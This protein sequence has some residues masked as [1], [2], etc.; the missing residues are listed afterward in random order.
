[1]SLIG[2]LLRPRNLAPVPLGVPVR[3]GFSAA[4]TPSDDLAN[5]RAYKSQGTVHS[6]VSLLASSA[7]KPDWRLY[8][9]Q[10]VD[11]RR[12]YTT[13]DEGSDQRTE[14]IRHQALTVLN[15]PAVIKAGGR[16]IVFFTRRRLFEL[17]GI[18]LETTGKSHWVV[19]YDPRASF[20]MGLWPVPP[21]RMTPVP[22]PEVFLAGWLYTSPD[23]RERIPLR[24]Q[25]VIY[26]CYPDPEDVYGGTGPIGSVLANI[27]AARYAVR[28]NRSFFQNSARPDGVIQLDPS[29]EDVDFDR[30]EEQ[31]REAHQ[32]VDR[33]HR[34][35][36]L[37]AGATWQQTGTSPKDMDFANL[38][39]EM[40]DEIREALGMHKVMTGVTDD[41]NRANAQTGEEVFSSWKIVPRLDRW[42]DVLNNQYLPLFGSTG[43]GVEF[44]YSFPMPLNREQ[45]NAEL[46]A[47][48]DAA[49]ALA[50][51]GVWDPDDILEVV[52]LPHMNT[53]STPAPA[54]A[55]AAPGTEG[56]PGGAQP[57]YA[58]AAWAPFTLND[59]RLA[60][61][62]G[63][64]LARLP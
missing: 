59:R 28:W 54:A 6:N 42:K 23:G 19:Q 61:V 1:V 14:V 38:S 12:R 27:D 10:P 3:S 20:P 30:M 53:I 16:D 18:W 32:G 26:N 62:N 49:A 15:R 8:R 48:S 34:I 51:L 39:L 37:E 22:D 44:D 17:S 25:D 36:I 33:A 45:D 60:Q 9:A 21:W 63:R 55:P 13:S 56:A 24:V 47:K 35:A 31:W 58:P 43:D 11:A 50:A 4:Y 46:K 29:A 57:D 2:K 64:P 5:V 41:V 7:A 52:G 40:R